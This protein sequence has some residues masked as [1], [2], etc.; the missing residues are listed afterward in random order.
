M[1][2]IA[3]QTG[4]RLMDEAL[5]RYKTALHAGKWQGYPDTITTLELPRYAVR[6]DI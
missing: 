3:L 1:P 5:G 6:F 2:P 4:R